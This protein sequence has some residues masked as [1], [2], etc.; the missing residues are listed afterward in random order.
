MYRQKTTDNFGTVK[1][2]IKYQD[3]LTDVYPTLDE[4]TTYCDTLDGIMRGNVCEYRKEF[5]EEFMY[6]DV[7]TRGGLTNLA[8]VTTNESTTSIKTDYQFNFQE[9][10]SVYDNNGSLMGKISTKP[11]VKPIKTKGN[12]RRE[13]KLYMW[14][15]DLG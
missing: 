9:N 8:G 1:Y 7:E 14:Y 2:S 11:R 10:M 3:D 13:E 12:R 15:L 5:I 6:D 4:R